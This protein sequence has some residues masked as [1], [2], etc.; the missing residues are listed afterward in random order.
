MAHGD[1][2]RKKPHA[3]TEKD[4][5]WYVEHIPLPIVREKAI[6]LH[7]DLGWR[8]LE[9]N[10]R[11]NSVFGI[12]KVTSGSNQ[13]KGYLA[14]MWAMHETGASSL[15]GVC[16]EVSGFYSPTQYGEEDPV[17]TGKNCTLYVNG[18]KIGKAD[19]VE[20]YNITKHPRHKTLI[21]AERDFDTFEG[22]VVEGLGE[23]GRQR[24]DRFGGEVKIQNDR[25]FGRGKFK[26]DT[27]QANVV[28]VKHKVSREDEV[29]Y[30]C[31]VD[32]LFKCVNWV[33]LIP[34]SEAEDYK[35]FL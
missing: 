7:K 30:P 26:L 15:V 12:S 32:D 5:E 2:P 9:K 23:V 21:G 28:E 34:R 10:L 8:K 29:E 6:E 31:R 16:D 19:K 20:G 14:K 13:Y 24:V 22:V 1:Q 27:D 33:R 11:E 17:P 3:F 4:K 25:K 35:I 18:K